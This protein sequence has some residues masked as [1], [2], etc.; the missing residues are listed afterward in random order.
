MIP[1]LSIVWIL[2]TRHPAF[3]GSRIGPHKHFAIEPTRDLD[4][5]KADRPQH[6]NSIF[7]PGHYLN[8][9]A[10]IR[11]RDIINSVLNGPVADHV[12]NDWGRGDDQPQPGLLDSLNMVEHWVSIGDSFTSDRQADGFPEPAEIGHSR[13]ERFGAGFQN[14]WRQHPADSTRRRFGDW[15]FTRKHAGNLDCDSF[16]VNCS[17]FVWWD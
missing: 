16:H 14:R 11:G 9:L 10:K 5:G 17:P 3:E 8:P 1:L 6:M 4:T 13:R 12:V 7:E 15:N 2:S